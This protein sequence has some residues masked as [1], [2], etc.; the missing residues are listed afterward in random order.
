MATTHHDRYQI[1]IPE[2]GNQEPN[3]LYKTL[4]SPFDVEKDLIELSELTDS[5]V[6][7]HIEAPFIEEADQGPFTAWRWAYKDTTASYTYFADALTSL[8]SQG[9]FLFDYDRLLKSGLLNSPFQQ[10]A[11]LQERKEEFFRDVHKLEHSQRK[12]SEI[13]DA[14]G[15]G[16][17]I[18]EGNSKLIWDVPYLGNGMEYTLSD[19][20]LDAYRDYWKDDILVDRVRM[21]DY[22]LRDN[23]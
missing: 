16:Y 6:F 22:M 2:T 18:E 8:R 17:W 15:R 21:D 11:Y 4:E 19:T 20:E 3:H 14:G 9:L 13:Y 1:L 10:N 5:T 23:C 12:R 7:D